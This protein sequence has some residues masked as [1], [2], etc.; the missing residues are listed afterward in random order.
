MELFEVDPEDEDD[1][2]DLKST[3]FLPYFLLYLDW[4]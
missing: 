2:I 1:Y 4:W 3:V